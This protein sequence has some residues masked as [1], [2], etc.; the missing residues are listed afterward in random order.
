M[1]PLQMELGGKDVCIVC[2]DADLDLAG[3]SIVKGAFSYSGQRCTAVKLVMVLDT[4][5]PLKALQC[6][7]PVDVM[8]LAT[9]CSLKALRCCLPVDCQRPLNNT[10]RK[11]YMHQQNHQST[12]CQ[13]RGH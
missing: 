4:V 8:V 6:C 9:V 7:S 5:C 2:A 13:H 1:I 3:K 10:G 11:A 12:P